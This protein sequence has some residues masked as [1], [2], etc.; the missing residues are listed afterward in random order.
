MQ[1]QR[2]LKDA[3]QTSEELSYKGKIF[4]YVA[5]ENFGPGIYTPVNLS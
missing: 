3:F 4:V 1:D 2:W 5:P